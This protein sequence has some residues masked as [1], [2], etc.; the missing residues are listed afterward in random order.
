MV[1][2]HLGRLAGALSSRRR[3]PADCHAQQV[4]CRAGAVLAEA[5]VRPRRAA[6]G[7]P[8]CVWR[9]VRRDGDPA[10]LPGLAAARPGRSADV[11]AL[12]YRAL[13]HAAGVDAR[14]TDRIG[15]EEAA[16]RARR[17]HPRQRRLAHSGMPAPR[18]GGA[19]RH[20]HRRPHARADGRGPGARRSLRRRHPRRLP[21]NVHV[22]HEGR[23]P[24]CRGGFP[25]GTLLRHRRLCAVPEPPHHPRGLGHRSA[26]AA[27]RGAPARG[28]QSGG[29]VAHDR[30]RRSRHDRR[31]AAGNGG[32][33]RKIPP[34]RNH[35]SPRQPRLR[36]GARGQTLALHRRDRRV[37]QQA[38][39]VLRVL[40]QPDPL[41]LG[42]FAGPD[43]GARD[44]RDSADPVCAAPVPARAPPAQARLPAAGHAVRS[45]R[46]TRIAARRCRRSSGGG[47]PRGAP[48][49]SALSAVSRC[50]LGAG[51]PLRGSASCRIHRR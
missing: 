38:A 10:R 43:L 39:Y 1:A 50:A 33:E 13:V 14:E 49:R 11:R 22:E 19:V 46:R 36:F 41:H 9:R 5:A 30:C 48:A 8:G 17:A 25:G 51:P 44:C 20:G 2:S 47:G 24:L 18:M 34:A 6:C 21:R 45:R 37:E 23:A 29:V 27:A 42:Y 3:D 35:R 12:R 16:Q 7:E 15:G 26:V 28:G 40:A 31:P 4:P 32:A